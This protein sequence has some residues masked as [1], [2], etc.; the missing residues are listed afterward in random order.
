[1]LTL[2]AVLTWSTYRRNL[3]AATED[4]PVLGETVPALQTSSATLGFIVGGLVL[5]MFGADQLIDGGV[6][7]AREL[8]V[9]NAIIGLTLIAIGSSLPEMTSCVIAAYRRQPGLAVGNVLGSNVFNILGAL[10]AASLIGPIPVDLLVLEVDIWLMLA[11]SAAMALFIFMG[12]DIGRGVGMLFLA[13]YAVYIAIHF[14][15]F[16]V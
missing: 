15:G 3:L 5:L 4:P 1:M 7:I 12:R 9:P 2:L 11:A 16:G 13:V 14:T 8:G 10:G 6:A